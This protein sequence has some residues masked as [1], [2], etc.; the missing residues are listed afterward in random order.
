MLVQ[1]CHQKNLRKSR[2]CNSER[3]Y[4]VIC[5]SYK[6][7]EILI[8]PRVAPILINCI[9]W[10]ADKSNITPLGFVIMPDHLHWAFALKQP[11]TLDN[12]IKI[13]KSFTAR[14]IGELQH[15]ENKVWQHG[16]Y[17]HMLRDVKDFRIKLDYMHNN[18]IR[19]GLIDRAE[20]YLYSTANE[21]YAHMVDWEYIGC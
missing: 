9:K 5:C 13:Y 7:S 14:K 19:K 2:I 3:L 21:R 15:N 17:E 18:P 12:I 20:D 11:Y 10:F 1:E 16:Y 6:K 4:F 8:D